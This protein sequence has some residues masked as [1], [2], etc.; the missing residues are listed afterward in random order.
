[1][2]EVY[3]WSRLSCYTLH[4]A[5][6]RNMIAKMIFTKNQVQL[7]QESRKLEFSIRE[8]GSTLYVGMPQKQNGH[9]YNAM[10]SDHCKT[11]QQAG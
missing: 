2:N 8:C 7:F 9:Q 11:H 10:Q 6:I 4:V 1:M 5:Q 3:S